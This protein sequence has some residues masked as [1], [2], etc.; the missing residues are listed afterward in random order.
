[1]NPRYRIRE[2][3]MGL[4][5]YLYLTGFLAFGCCHSIPVI[6]Q[7][8]Y[9]P[10]K[11]ILF[12]VVDDLKPELGCYGSAIA[13]TPH[14]DDWAK[15]A[16]R[17]DLAYCQQAVCGPSRSSVLT[18]LRPDRIRVWDLKTKLRHENPMVTTLPQHFK[19][20]GYQTMGMGKVFDMSNTDLK[21]DSVSWT[22]P[23]KKVFPL[24]TGYEDIAY[25]I[26]QSPEVKRRVSEK[27]NGGKSED[28]FYGPNKD[29]S[30]RFSTECLDVPDNSYMDGAMADYAVQQLADLKRASAPFFLAVGFKKPHLPFIAP[31][32]YW[33]LYD[34][35]ILPL[36]V[37]SQRA[38]NAPEIA[39]HGAGELR[40]YS[41][42]IVPIK[43][44]ENMLLLPGEKQ[45]ELI[46]GYYACISY[47]DVQIGKILAALRQEGLDKNTIVVLW[48]DHGWHLGDHQLWCKHSNFEQ[49][50][51]TPLLISVPGVTNGRNYNY[52][53][54]LLDI[55]PTL[56]D[57][58]NVPKPAYL[59]GKSLKPVL[60]TSE[61]LTQ[62]YAISQYPRWYKG[63]ARGV[64]GYTIRD[65]Q[66]RYTLWLGNEFNT[67]KPAD[68]V[69]VIASELYD[70]VDDPHER[71]NK[72][73]D[74]KLTLVRARLHEKLYAYFRDQHTRLSLTENSDR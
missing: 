1:M 33:D 8:Q 9:P 5:K 68:S 50:V 69:P 3:L 38:E 14:I 21:G 39:H 63:N 49:A 27:G 6:S 53:V 62:N 43:S 70:Y 30:I 28:D 54:E 57:V 7:R 18:G 35:S 55:F 29:S 2:A 15:T 64:M 73:D 12:I 10:Q 36:A 45:R 47:V 11:N 42:D 17:F 25:G 61:N 65:E 67:S 74:S 4:E 51:R 71:Y 46:H 34:R 44:P 41:G 24:A 20:L 26:Y 22:Y 52:P 72:I 16:T 19:N 23:F 48:G 59:D 66:Y 31:K 32:K 60:G 13:K 37:N 58:A 40:N 56:C